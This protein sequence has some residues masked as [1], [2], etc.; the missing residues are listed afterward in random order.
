MYGRFFEKRA[1]P[2]RKKTPPGKPEGASAQTNP[3]FLAE[4]GAVFHLLAFRPSDYSSA[5]YLMVRTI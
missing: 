3:L 2:A 1:P 4:E 5:K